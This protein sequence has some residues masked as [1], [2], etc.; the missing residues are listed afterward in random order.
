M[1]QEEIEFETWGKRNWLG[2]MRYHARIRDK[3]NGNILFSTT[4]QGY[5]RHIDAH[6]AASKVQRYAAIA[7]IKERST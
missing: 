1:G 4:G 2:K 5:S 7:D 3:S 6:R